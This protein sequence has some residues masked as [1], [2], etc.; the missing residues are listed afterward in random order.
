LEV[1]SNT[2]LQLNNNKKNSTSFLIQ[3]IQKKYKKNIKKN[4]NGEI[5]FS[6]KHAMIYIG[7]CYSQLVYL[8]IPD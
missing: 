6:L 7:V 3:K 8:I 1:V 5:E 4:K 2:L